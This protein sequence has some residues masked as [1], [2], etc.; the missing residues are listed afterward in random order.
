MLGSRLVVAAALLALTPQATPFKTVYYD[1][2]GLRLEAYL[3]EPKGT[4]PFPVVIFNHGSRQGSERVERP[5]QFIGAVLTEAGYAVLVPERREPA[6]PREQAP[7]RVQRLRRIA[8]AGEQRA[9][10][11]PAGVGPDRPNRRGDQEGDRQNCR[12]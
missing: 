3:Y 5:F 11:S 7:Q 2:A 10:E 8:C 12:A 1:N 9:D 4:G 6:P